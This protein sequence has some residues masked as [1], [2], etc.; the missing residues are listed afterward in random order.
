MNKREAKAGL[1]GTFMPYTER[2][3]AIA[4]TRGREAIVT[5][6]QKLL[7]EHGF[8]EQQWRV[9]RILYDFEPIASAEVCRRS[10]IHKVSMARILKALAARGL[11]RRERSKS[12]LRGYNVSLT[13]KGRRLLDEL[14][15]LASTIYAGITAE[16]GQEKTRLLLEL[17]KDLAKINVR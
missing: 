7:A 12:D 8:T 17:L 14:T 6:F 11:V 5:R 2:S 9:L 3:L 16:F 4:C 13:N 1:D 15:P 10:C